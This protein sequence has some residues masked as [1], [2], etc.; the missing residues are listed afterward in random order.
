MGMCLR[1]MTTA[2]QEGRSQDVP[3]VL[4]GWNSNDGNGAS[5]ELPPGATPTSW[6]QRM[7][8]DFGPEGRSIIGGV[9]DD[10]DPAGLSHRAAGRPAARVD[11][12]ALRA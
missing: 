5:D 2:Y 3:A 8:N 9:M 12:S 11:K 4:A 1:R 6:E 10:D 7:L